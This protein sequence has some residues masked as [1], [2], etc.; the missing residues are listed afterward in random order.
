MQ[1]GS[2]LN[3]NNSNR[4]DSNSY[5]GDY[6]EVSFHDNISQLIL[7]ENFVKRKVK[8]IDFNCLPW[9]EGCK[10]SEKNG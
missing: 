4:N 7:N 10:I 3:L 2:Y 8:N 9:S 5:H 1:N 6:G